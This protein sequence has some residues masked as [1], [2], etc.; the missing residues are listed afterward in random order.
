VL[1]FIGSHIARELLNMGEEVRVLDNF[2]TGK[3]ENTAPFIG[4]I[5]LIEGDLRDLDVVK[6]AVQGVN[7]ILHQGVSLLCLARSKIPFK[8]TG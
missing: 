1:V 2:S 8:Q 3:R 7:Y 5:E 6:E 4:K